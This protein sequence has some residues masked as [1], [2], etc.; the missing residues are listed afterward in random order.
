MMNTASELTCHTEQ[1]RH[2]V[3]R[4]NTY[5]GLDY[6][7]VVDATHLRLFF[8]KKAPAGLT[9]AN[10]V[11]KGGR[12]PQYRDLKVIDLALCR[13][14]REE[15]DDC[16][17]I[18]LDKTGDFSCYTL[19]LVALDEQGYPTE[20]PFPDLDP[21][22]ACVDFSF[23]IDCPSELDC[24]QEQICPIQEYVEPEINYLARD[25]AGFR[26]LILDRLAVTMPAWRE[27]HVPDIGI[28]VIEALAY[29]GDYLSYYQDAVATEA[30]LATARRRISVRRHARLVDYQM[31]E[32]CNARTWLH[33]HTTED[34]SFVP[35]TLSFITRLSN[36]PNLTDRLLMWEDLR[37]VPVN[38][39][40]VFEPVV[41]TPD[42]PIHLYAA[43][44]EIYFYSW[45]DRDCCLPRGATTATLVDGHGKTPPP[46]SPIDSKDDGSTKDATSTKK[47]AYTR[48]L[49]LQIGDVLIFE[50]VISPSTGN[51][52][53][54]DPT[55]RHV[56][57]LTQV[58]KVIDD[59]Y[60][61]PLLEIEWAQ[62]DALPFPLCIS[63]VGPAPECACL[64]NISVARG[65]VLLVDHGR[66]VAEE[67]LGTVPIQS[68]SLVCLGGEQPSDVTQIPG[69]FQPVLQAGN[70]TYHQP[71]AFSASAMALLTQDPR[72]AVPAI[73]LSSTPPTTPTQLEQPADE[74]QTEDG[75]D[76]V[77]LHPPVAATDIPP[78]LMIAHS[79]SQTDWWPQRD[80]LASDGDD[81]HFVAEVDNDGRVHLRFGDGELG[82]A[83]AA[84]EQFT[85]T[86]RV[87]NGTVGNVGADTIAH[88][89]TEE[90]VS[91]TIWS[92]NPLPAI[93]GVNPET[94][95]DVKLF[96][97]HAFRRE[98][99]RA[100]IADDY[101]EIL[102]RDFPNVIQ[103]A[104]AVLRWA[105]SWY[106]VLVV[107]DPVGQTAADPGLLDTIQHH[108]YRFRRMG[109]DVVVRLADYV[110]LEIA[111]EICVLPAYLRG[112]VKA[113]LQRVFS[114]RRL[115]DGRLGFFHPDNLTFGEGIYLSKIVA[116]AQ[117]VTGVESVKVTKLQRFDELPNNEIANGILPLDMLEIARLDSDP[118]A[119]ENGY[120]TLTMRGGR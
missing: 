9:A 47:A 42:E 69:C 74:A 71:P 23:K 44:N 96:A 118:N 59:L 3:R 79:D 29:V 108:L 11:V 72:A 103:R 82:R 28:T 40:E 84:G 86:Y 116:A 8:L 65:N 85:A 107:V 43:H 102:M 51:R 2:A 12:R 37:A 83:P 113:E 24:K 14:E 53:D 32:G 92:R 34:S 7:D 45:G 111:L 55:H 33:L 58:N 16:L 89:I 117:A 73:R 88:V 101:A 110:P 105:G 31:H 15:L 76:D 67:A 39:Y 27:R 87:G 4:H 35:N 100:I 106:E 38:R 98:R 81:T 80:L 93:G 90:I 10:V 95:A 1:R 62:E 64:T 30:Y 19:C 63:A 77:N 75:D 22:Y 26:Q 6:L 78:S 41:A 112:H 97:P 104:A 50:E 119:P 68:T 94:M 57:R 54:A 52:S 20:Q 99:R 91:K 5:N 13:Q 56:V 17:L 109:H 120:L 115:P 66:R 21:R 48:E 18:T 46:S 25:Y 61:R 70:V 114:T 60:D 36:P 49:H